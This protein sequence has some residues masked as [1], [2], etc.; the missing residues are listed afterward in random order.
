MRTINI[1]LTKNYNNPVF[2]GYEGEHN[3]TMLNIKIPD[4]IINELYTYRVMFETSLDE[5]YTL[6]PLGNEDDSI[7]S[8][9]LNANVTK[10]GILY[11]QVEAFQ[12]ETNESNND[13]VYTF[14]GKTIKMPLLIKESVGGEVGSDEDLSATTAEML[15]AEINKIK[16]DTVFNIRGNVTNHDSEPPSFTLTFQ[17][18]NS[19]GVLIDKEIFIEEAHLYEGDIYLYKD[20]SNNWVINNNLPSSSNYTRLPMLIGTIAYTGSSYVFKKGDED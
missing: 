20:N 13:T 15:L 5:K 18:Y 9:Y 4:D 19:N 8:T 14:I 11:I 3:Q 12:T 6:E 1:D 17:T 2:V 10:K 16:S 7:I